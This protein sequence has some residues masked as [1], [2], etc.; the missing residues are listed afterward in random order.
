MKRFF[1]AIL[2][3]VLC[4]SG[5]A[6]KD[7]SWQYMG[8]IWLS[9][10]RPDN[11]YVSDPEL[12]ML[13]SQFDGENMNYKVY[14]PA[15]DCAYQ[16]YRNRSFSLEYYEAYLRASQRDHFHGPHLKISEQYPMCAGKYYFDPAHVFK[17]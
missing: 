9:Y 14:V 6:Q 7:S 3:S 10:A 2:L 8:K 1:I 13:Y 5:Y 12:G 11:A 17:K 4:I 16:A 15:Q